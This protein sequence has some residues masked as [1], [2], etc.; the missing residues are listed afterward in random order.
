MKIN[1]YKTVKFLIM[2]PLLTSI[3]LFF[4]IAFAHGQKTNLFYSKQQQ[5]KAMA[6]FVENLKTVYVKGQTFEDFEQKLIANATNTP[7]GKALLKRAHQFLVEETPKQK[8]E[9]TYTG[10]EIENA[11]KFNKKEAKQF[12]ISD[13]VTLFG[14]IEVE[15]TAIAQ[16]SKSS[17]CRW[18]QIRCLM[19][20]ISK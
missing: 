20:Q 15:K 2:K 5:A 17:G 8:I 12:S 14:G 9:T 1:V 18:Y 16:K 4:S 6:L 11:I 7:E 19:E 13:E 3:L 10:L